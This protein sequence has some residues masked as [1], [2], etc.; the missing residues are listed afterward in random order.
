MKNILNCSLIREEKALN[1]T[2]LIKNDLN[3]KSL[4]VWGDNLYSLVGI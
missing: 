1:K 4:V 2:D 3:C